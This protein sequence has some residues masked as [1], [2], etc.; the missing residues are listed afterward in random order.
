MMM[1]ACVGWGGQTPSFFG[2]LSTIV[3]DEKLTSRED[4]IGLLFLYVQSDKNMFSKVDKVLK[5]N[6]R[7]LIS[8]IN[9]LV[10]PSFEFE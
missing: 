10:A 8:L 2:S 6:S 3:D 1:K 4:L 9:L 7:R 5:P